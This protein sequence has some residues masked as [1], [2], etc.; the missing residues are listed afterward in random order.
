M[1]WSFFSYFSYFIE[2]AQ[3]QVHINLRSCTKLNPTPLRCVPFPKFQKV[4]LVTLP[5]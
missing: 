3:K 4:T 1:G 5:S 2:I